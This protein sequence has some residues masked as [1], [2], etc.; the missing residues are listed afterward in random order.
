M[1]LVCDTGG[2]YALYD[3]DDAYH[4]AARAAVEQERG[5]LIVPVAILS[6]IDY[7]LSRRLGTKAAIDFL[8]SIQAGAFTLCGTTSEDIV[9]CVELVQQY[10]DMGLGL[11]DSA[12]VAIAERLRVQRI[13]TVDHRHFRAVRPRGFEFFVVVPTDQ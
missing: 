5:A 12:V 10:E 3:A 4:S 8:R 2:V 9:R 1:A 11:A 7:L 13:L 6:E